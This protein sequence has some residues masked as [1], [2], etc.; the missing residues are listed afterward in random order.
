MIVATLRIGASPHVQPCAHAHA[1]A[2][3]QRSIACSRCATTD[4][5]RLI[6]RVPAALGVGCLYAVFSI[7]AIRWDLGG[8][9][10]ASLR[11]SRSKWLIPSFFARSLRYH[12]STTA[13]CTRVR[14]PHSSF[15]HL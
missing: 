4:G 6:F 2:S 13:G 14:R 3:H 1:P 12:K 8:A 15:M 11:P 9:A 7:C 10:H 5:L